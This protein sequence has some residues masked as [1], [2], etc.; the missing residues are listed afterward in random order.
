MTVPEIM[1]Q[2]MPDCISGIM[3]ATLIPHVEYKWNIKLY[4]TSVIFTVSFQA[5]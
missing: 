3:V 4:D 1:E 5:A 2:M